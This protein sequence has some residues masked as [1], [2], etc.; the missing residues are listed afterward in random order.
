MN[1]LSMIVPVYNDEKNI[2]NSI[3]S[4]LNQ[5]IPVDIIVVNDGSTD[6]TESIVQELSKKHKNIKYYKKVNKGIACARN[7]G[8]S[9]VKTKYFGFLDSDDTCKNDMAEKMINEIEKTKSDVCFSNF[10]WVYPDGTN[11]LS[12]D[13][14]YQNKKEIITKM[15]ATLWNKIYKTSWF[16]KTKIKFPEGL[17]YEDASILYRLVPYMDKVCY[18]SDSFVFYNQRSKSIT[19][20]FDVNVDNM[21]NVFVGILNEYKKKKLFNMY[22][23][24]LEYITI[25]FF[26]G[27]S[28]LRTCRIDDVSIRN[29]ILNKS[30]T[31]LNNQFPEF[32]NNKYLLEKGFKN[33][34]YKRITQ[35]KFYG[36]VKFI[37]ILYLLGLLK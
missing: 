10:T 6:S 25:R 32:N 2:K 15:Y 21:I 1:K 23:D 28:Y 30:W 7:Y 13:T 34:Y 27:N 35:S 11:K 5:T 14:G 18:V 37:R 31:F 24:E 3:E 9:K 29:S 20:T 4:L 33:N 19:H 16:K 22:K 17:Q 8:L 26:L 12:I 36:N